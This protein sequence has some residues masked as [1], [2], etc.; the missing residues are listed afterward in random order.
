MA[1]F[2]VPEFA[3]P[4]LHHFVTEQEIELVIKI[5]GNS[6]TRDQIASLFESS[7]D[8]DNL[9]EQAYQ[10]YV[11][12]KEGKDGTV[13]YR[14]SDFYSR[15]DDQSKFGNY[16]VLPQKIRQQLDE[17]CY[18]EYLKRNNHFKV[19]VDNDPN[20]E[21]CHN[22]LILLL[23]EVEEMIDA[24]EKIMVLPCNCKMLADNCDRP[25]E[26]C[27]F[28]DGHITDRTKGR[29]LSREEAKEL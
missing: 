9:L 1:A 24:A 17:W 7:P 5:A 18:L 26:V 20:Y 22:D 27:L 10:R 12:N 8:I 16:Y 25:R 28:F 2:Q 3:K 21:N 4:Y 19:V 14:I 11:I 23:S 29:L 13:Y 6:L 15:L